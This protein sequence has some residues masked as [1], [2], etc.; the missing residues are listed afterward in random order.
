MGKAG[1]TEDFI[2]APAW[3]ES[4]FG[5]DIGRLIEGNGGDVR[6][7]VDRFIDGDGDVGG[8]AGGVSL[9]LVAVVDD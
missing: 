3:I 7:T 4:D 2:V 9:L 6:A 1:D 8:V 5:N